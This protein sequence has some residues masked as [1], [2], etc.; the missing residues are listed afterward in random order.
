MNDQPKPGKHHF[1]P[2]E[3]LP[4]FGYCTTPLGKYRYEVTLAR[5]LDPVPNWWSTPLAPNEYK[6]VAAVK[7]PT[8]A[9]CMTALRRCVR[10]QKAIESKK[11][12]TPTT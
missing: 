12:G 1:N 8:R 11:K 3:Q 4:G 9:A 6:V 10:E 7:K 5:I 2:V